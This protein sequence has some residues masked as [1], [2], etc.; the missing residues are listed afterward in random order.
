MGAMADSKVQAVQPATVNT[1]IVWGYANCPICNQ[2]LPNFDP[3]NPWSYPHMVEAHPGWLSFQRKLGR[4]AKW[5]VLPL[6]FLTIFSFPVSIIVMTYIPALAVSLSLVAVVAVFRIYSR[7]YLNGSIS[8]WKSLHGEP[9]SIGPIVAESI[10]ERVSW[11]DVSTRK[12]S[13]LE[14]AD[15][16]ILAIVNELIQ[17]LKL[18]KKPV[19][20]ISWKDII[21]AGKSRKLVHSDQPIQE[22]WT[23]V[24]ANRARGRLAPEDWRPLIASSLIYNS[25]SMRWRLF[26]HLLLRLFLPVFVTF[27]LFF[28]ALVWTY[29]PRQAFL[30]STVTGI[31]ILLPMIFAMLLT[32][33][34]SPSYVRKVRLLSDRSASEALSNEAF[35]HSLAAVG[36]QG[37][38]DVLD[39]ESRGFYFRFSTTPRLSTRESN[40]RS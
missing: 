28:L 29:V 35:L 10:G 12:P 3:H 30:L 19:T 40:L 26:R 31:Y 2:K 39:L 33:G 27:S 22:M 1:A 24:L 6:I 16:S 11:Q 5:T 38:S 20:E 15:A 8:E 21:G 18:K 17:Q 23:L 36:R 25:P 14:E 4:I 13:S 9:A 34:L 32:K 37:F 7:R